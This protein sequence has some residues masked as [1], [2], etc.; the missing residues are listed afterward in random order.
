MSDGRCPMLMDWSAKSWKAS[1]FQ[2][3]ERNIWNLLRIILKA[4]AVPT[5]PCC[6]LVEMGWLRPNHPFS[7]TRYDS[8]QDLIITWSLMLFRIKKFWI[9]LEFSILMA[10]AQLKEIKRIH[11]SVMGVEIVR[12]RLIL[13]GS[14][15]I[16]PL[17][18]RLD[19]LQLLQIQN[20]KH[21][22][23]AL[24]IKVKYCA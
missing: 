8:K 14:G 12:V 15:N 22:K 3:Y 6:S 21:K 5:F 23:G 7:I 11:F 19:Q 17:F 9:P 2:D 1:Y 24:K 4:C 20:G 16:G 13:V 10:E 18:A